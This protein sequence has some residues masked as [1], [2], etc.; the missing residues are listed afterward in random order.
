MLSGDFPVNFFNGFNRIEVPRGNF[1]SSNV[2]AL[3]NHEVIAERTNAS[4]INI[5]EQKGF[6]VYSLDLSEF[7]KGTGGPSCLILPAY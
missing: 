2:I 1:V 6:R 7:N 4:T 3:G 5:L